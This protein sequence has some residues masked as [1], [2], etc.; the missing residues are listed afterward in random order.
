MYYDA[1]GVGAGIRSHYYDMPARP[2]GMRGVNFG[3]SPEGEDQEYTPGVTNEQ[4]F[5]RRNAQMGWG[6]RLRANATQRLT[7][8]DRVVRPDQCL[9]HKSGHRV[10]GG[11]AGPVVATGVVGGYKRPDGRR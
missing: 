3:G 10:R 8:G 1:G 5:S 11:S 9:F 4:F 6:L 2:Y 7:D